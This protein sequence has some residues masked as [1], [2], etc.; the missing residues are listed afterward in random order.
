[1][2]HN[3]IFI[4]ITIIVISA[5]P[6]IVA[7]RWS[8]SIPAFLPEAPLTGRAEHSMFQNNRLEYSPIDPRVI[9]KAFPAVNPVNPGGVATNTVHLKP[10]TIEQLADA[11]EPQEPNTAP[12]VTF[13]GIITGSDNIAYTFIKDIATGSITSIREAINQEEL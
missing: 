3:I 2:K 10:Q 7:L 8:P 6:P 5:I 4:F 1:M 12:E 11:P 9:S 13:L